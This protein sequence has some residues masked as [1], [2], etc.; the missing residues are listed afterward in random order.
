MTSM[1]SPSDLD[2]WRARGFT[3][4]TR[5]ARIEESRVSRRKDDSP[6]NP[7]FP[8]EIVQQICRSLKDINC[9]RT[10]GNMQGVSRDVYLVATPIL[11]ET[12]YIGRDTGATFFQ[13]FDAIPEDD[14]ALAC[15]PIRSQVEQ[16]QHLIDMT[17]PRRLRWL[18]SYVVNVILCCTPRE[19]WFDTFDR[20]SQGIRDLYRCQELFSNVIGLGLESS[21]IHHMMEEEYGYSC[22]HYQLVESFQKVSGLRHVCLRYPDDDEDIAS[23][24][25]VVDLDY[26]RRQ[27][28]HN[29]LMDGHNRDGSLYTLHSE[30]GQL[31]RFGNTLTCHNMTSQPIPLINSDSA[32][33]RVRFVDYGAV[34]ASAQSVT[35]S[36]RV[37]QIASPLSSSTSDGSDHP[38]WTFIDPLLGV[39]VTEE[40]RL[41]RSELVPVSTKNAEILR[42]M[43]RKALIDDFERLELE[44][45][46]SWYQNSVKEMIARVEFL[47]GEDVG[48]QPPWLCLW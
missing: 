48:Y 32:D 6:H 47:N 16:D 3:I 17:Y 20:I 43:V 36:C 13:L 39:D 23:R 29:Y 22:S 37:A 46:T 11:F 40:D 35:L 8:I 34:D 28:T 14:V 4:S 9:D 19:D 2:Y 41:V 7:V 25:R 45:D 5:S 18:C 33:V 15:L 38:R 21:V 10:L 30:L 31:A 1:S 24:P 44:W 12:L 27:T 26:F 42:E